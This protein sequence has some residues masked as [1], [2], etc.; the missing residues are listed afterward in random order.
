VTDCLLSAALE[1]IPELEA[2][3]EPQ[4]SPQTVEEQHD[5]AEPTPMPQVLRRAHRG[6]GGVGC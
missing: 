6:P 4:E 2:P 1:R 5:R 3:S